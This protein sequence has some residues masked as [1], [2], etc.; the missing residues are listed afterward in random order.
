M[1]RDFSDML[2]ALNDSGAEHLVVGAYAMAFHVYVR[3]TTEI[4]IW[5]R[6]TPENAH[7]VWEALGA[8]GAPTSHLTEA[9]LHAPDMVYQFGVAPFRIDLLSGIDGV[10]FDDAWAKRQQVA[11]AGLADQR[12][13]ERAVD[14]EQARQRQAP[15]MQATWSGCNNARPP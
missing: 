1:H 9:D 14:P 11:A 7:R 6:P 15:R 2:S 3:A 12:S 5:L 10:D 13:R 4:D 8:F